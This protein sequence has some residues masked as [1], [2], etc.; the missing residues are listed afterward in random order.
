[1]NILENVSKHLKEAAITVLAIVALPFH[2]VHEA[3]H[4]KTE[5]LKKDL[6]KDDS[7]KSV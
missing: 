1:M 4:K 5:E 7:S 2:L 6:E 3:V